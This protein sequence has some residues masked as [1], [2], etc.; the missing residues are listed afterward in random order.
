MLFLF[1]FH[2]LATDSSSTVAPIGV[3]FCMIV[4]IGPGQVSSLLG[5]VTPEDP[6]KSEILGLTFGHLTANILKT[7]TVIILELNISSTR[8][9]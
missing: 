3:K 9:F 4:D 6:Q 7:L 8:A 2:C 1:F 5:A